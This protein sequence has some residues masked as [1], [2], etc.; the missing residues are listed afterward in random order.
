MYYT[1]SELSMTFC[2]TLYA[3][4][5]EGQESKDKSEQT[6]SDKAI[7]HQAER[8]ADIERPSSKATKSKTFAVFNAYL[9]LLGTIIGFG[10]LAFYPGHKL[11]ADIIFYLSILL[12]GLIPVAIVI[13]LLP[14]IRKL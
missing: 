5:M 11:T 6:A 1:M 4:F 9:I 2:D 7:E 10:V 12:L 14:I 3:L 13:Y 8:L